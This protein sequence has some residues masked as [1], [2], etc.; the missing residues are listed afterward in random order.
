MNA[1]NALTQQNGPARSD[2][3]AAHRR[4]DRGGRAHDDGKRR[5]QRSRSLASPPA[6][7]TCRRATTRPA[8]A[9]IGFPG[10]RFTWAGGFGAPTLF[11][12]NGNSQSVAIALG[13]PSEVEPNDDIAAREPAHR[14]QLRRREHHDAGRARHV[15]RDDRDAG[16]LHLRDVGARRIVRTWESSST[17]SFP[18]HHRPAWWSGQRQFHV[19]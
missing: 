2:D 9:P 10:R 1:Y 13:F 18:S 7:T 19:S 8:T 16:D 12:V 17:R 3:R 15:P 14:G 4:D 11:N 6:R 5:R